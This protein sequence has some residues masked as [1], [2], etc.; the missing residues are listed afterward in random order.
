M[1]DINDKVEGMENV[2]TEEVVTE[3]PNVSLETD[4][5]KEEVAGEVNYRYICPACSGNAFY[6]R[7]LEEFHSVCQNCAK[8]SIERFEGNYVALTEDDRQSLR[9]LAK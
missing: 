2:Q 6:A 9:D 1:N 4:T 7:S 5:V 8:A 3:I